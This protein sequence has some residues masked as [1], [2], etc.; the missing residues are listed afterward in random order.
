[1]LELVKPLRIR[2][3]CR[4]GASGAISAISAISGV[5]YNSGQT[6]QYPPEIE[7]DGKIFKT[8]EWTN[9]P[10]FI[11]E[12]TKRKL[13]QNPDH[14]IGILR[15]L[16]EKNMKDMGY[17]F[18]NNFKPAVT[19][20]QN[21]DVLGFPEDHPG[22]SKSDTYYLNKDNLLRTHTSAHE[23]ECFQ[24]CETPGY[25]ITAD[26]YRKDEIDKTHYPAFH[27][28]EGARIWSKDTPNLEEQIMKDIE[29]IPKTN[30]IVED[31]FRQHPINENN[32]KQ[33]YMSDRQVELISV[34]L[35]KLIEYLVNQVFETARESARKAGSTEPYL[36][37][38]LKV[39]WVEAYF[40]WTSPSWEIEVWWKGEWLECCGCGIV[41]QQVLL[42]AGLGDDKLGWAFGIGIDR[43]AMLLF[44]IPDI[45]LF[46]SLD[47]RF[48]N[49]F[50]NGQIATFAPYSK[51]PGIKRDVSF[52]LPTDSLLH[53]ND[54]MEIVR[55]YAGDVAESVANIDEFVHPKTGKKSQC[56]RINYQSMDRN[57]TNE[58]INEVHQKVELDLKK[59]FGVEIR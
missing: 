32:P 11:L 42:N 9:I 30:I 53:E 22:R 51:Y 54:V 29:S 41:Q 7:L 38:P 10:P 1:M 23:L 35:K 57:L 5:R 39:R 6:R 27:Q 4:T 43:I 24:T 37:E 58:E 12:L 21:F 33:D 15:S 2:F 47:E 45:R 19:T 20:Y 40:P 13:H 28:L 56:Y 17:T 18:Y 34:H 14:P 26:V 3:F 16:I 31:P 46:W 49:Q 44:G 25:L 59:Y 50:N 55:T 48:H 52:W 36:N 8:D